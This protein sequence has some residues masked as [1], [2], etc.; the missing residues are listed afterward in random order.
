MRL[1]HQQVLAGADVM[2]RRHHQH[3]HQKTNAALHLNLKQLLPHK[4][5]DSQAQAQ[6]RLLATHQIQL[7]FG[8]CYNAKPLETT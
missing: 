2:A 7:K 6:V 3:Y 8:P 1:W 5:G 4:L